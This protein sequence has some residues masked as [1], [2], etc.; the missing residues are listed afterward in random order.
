MPT[1]TIPPQNFEKI[2]PEKVFSKTI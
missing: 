2:H 1:F